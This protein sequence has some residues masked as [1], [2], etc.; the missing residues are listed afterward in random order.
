[1]TIGSRAWQRIHRNSTNLY[2]TINQTTIKQC[3]TAIPP[4]GLAQTCLQHPQALLAAAPPHGHLHMSPQRHHAPRDHRQACTPSR[5]SL[6]GHRQT[7]KT[8]R[9]RAAQRCGQAC[10]R[11]LSVPET[12]PHSEAPLLDPAH[13]G[14]AVQHWPRT[15]T[16]TCTV[17]ST[18]YRSETSPRAPDPTHPPPAAQTPHP[19]P[20]SSSSACSPCAS[21]TASSPAC[22]PTPSSAP[23]C[24][25][26]TASSPSTG[27]ATT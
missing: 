9:D 20:P 11:T 17:L 16:Q 26:S 8:C 15:Y 19:R 27:P 18:T 14:R 4:H 2:T 24:P 21:R 23:T 3:S 10:T 6:H 7:W 13:R 22:I 12:S 5:A 25:G 1:M